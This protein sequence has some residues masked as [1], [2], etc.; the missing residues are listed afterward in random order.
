MF[1]LGFSVWG[2]FLFVV[3]GFFVGFCCWLV[4]WLGGFFV[5]QVD[6]CSQIVLHKWVEEANTGKKLPS[7][8]YPK[9]A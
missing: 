9:F 2:F 3:L 8:M 6:K 1:V 4:G 5:T 7:Y